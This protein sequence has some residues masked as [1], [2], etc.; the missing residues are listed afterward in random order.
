MNHLE[1]N[2]KKHS[3]KHE[4]V[5]TRKQNNL[6]FVLSGFRV[7][8]MKQFLR[9]DAHLSILKPEARLKQMCQNLTSNRGFLK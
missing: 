1:L 8:A 7:F 6:N 4:M 5:Q 2:S 3:G 9:V